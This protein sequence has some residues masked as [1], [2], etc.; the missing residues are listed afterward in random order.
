VANTS[1]E[2]SSSLSIQAVNANVA[3]ELRL[4]QLEANA[5]I[6]RPSIAIA[7][8][9]EIVDP[10][11]GTLRGARV[12]VDNY[13]AAQDRLGIVGQTGNSGILAGTS[14]NWAI[15]STTGVISFDGIAD[16]FVYQN[17]LRQVTFSTLSSTPSTTPRNVQ[18]VL[19]NLLANPENGHFYQFV[20][21]N[22]IS[23][24]DARN[25]ATNGED[26]FGLQGYLA[27]ITSSREQ[28]FIQQR[29]QGNGWIGASDASTPDDWRWVTGPEGLENNGAGRQFWSGRANGSVVSGRYANWQAEEPNDFG[30]DESYAHIIGNSSAYPED[31]TAIGKWND[32]RDAFPLNSPY[33]PLGYIV[34]YGGFAGEGTLKFTGSVAVN[35]RSQ[36]LA[37]TGGSNIT[38]RNNASGENAIWQLN[39]ATLLDSAFITPVPDKNWTMV[40]SGDFNGDGQDDLLWRNQ[41]SGDN[42]IWLKDGTNLNSFSA[43]GQKFITRVQDTN[44]KMITAAD[45]D[46]D[47]R[48][49]ILWR[50]DVTG[51]NAVWFMDASSTTAD[52]RYTS[53]EQFFANRIRN[54]D[55]N[56]KMVGAG[57]F[58]ADSKADIVWRN[59]VTGQNAIWLMDGTKNTPVASK[60]NG[61]QFISS[62]AGSNWKIVG[63]GDFNGDNK[64]D[65]AWRNSSTGEN[66]V[67]TINISQTNSSVSISTTEQFIVDGNGTKVLVAGNDW[68]IEAIGDT[69]NDGRSDLIWRNYATDENAVWQMN[70]NIS[71]ASGR[72]TITRNGAT[73]LTG[74]LNWDIVD[75][76]IA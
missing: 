28:D 72:R 19:G 15:N 69:D 13:D 4:N 74:K 52:G 44:W 35:V 56:W 29:I 75:S 26:Y 20:T 67:W 61:E 45:F 38:W 42:A 53:N 66:A 14:I 2:S 17:A 60:A 5:F 51:E 24:T 33:T 76:Y 23:W 73:V 34:E 25:A 3:P 63:I 68:R 39:S 30:G 36:S 8:N 50:N 12:F 32:L 62:L 27:T 1:L 37:I 70:G 48:A 31:S 71:A 21:N 55:R 65:L 57:N 10:D 22:G 46:G 54:V 41:S 40:A 64:S 6:G 18:F 43:A 7:P 47:S 9:L 49:D 16:N 59:E 58:D 11:G